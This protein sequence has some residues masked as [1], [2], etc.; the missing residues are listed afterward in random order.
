MAYNKKDEFSRADKKAAEFARALSHPARI[1]I[2]RKLAKENKCICGEIVDI[3][4]LAQST[5]SQ[6]LKD[7][8]SSGL[9]QGEIDGATSCYC[10][11]TTNLEKEID[12]FMKLLEM[13]KI[14]IKENKCC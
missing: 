12:D 7:L 10:I 6:H 1:A 13:F 8:K 11:N 4:P 9:V 5:V 14:K 2:L 3:M